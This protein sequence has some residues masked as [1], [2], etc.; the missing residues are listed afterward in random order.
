MQKL[1]LPVYRPWADLSALG[2]KSFVPSIS[3]ASSYN[4]AK[5]I[6]NDLPVTQKGVYQN[7]DK[8][9]YLNNTDKWKKFKDLLLFHL[10]WNIDENLLNIK[11]NNF[12]VIDIIKSLKDKYNNDNNLFIL[13][14]YTDY[15]N[16]EVYSFTRSIHKY[17]KTK[18]G[19]NSLWD[20]ERSVLDY[21]CSSAVEMSKV[22]LWAEIIKVSNALW[23]KNLNS[24]VENV[25]EQVELI[26]N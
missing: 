14:E 4:K 19:D 11:K 7:M 15:L 18:S 16:S 10:K 22:L 24:L 17:F 5:K 21:Y 9:V 26:I 25:E 2:A 12:T 13:R 23:I 1:Y 8:L 6:F 3:I 20:E